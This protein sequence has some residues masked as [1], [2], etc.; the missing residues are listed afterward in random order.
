MP[1]SKENKQHKQDPTQELLLMRMSIQAVKEKVCQDLDAMVAQIERL[2]PPENETRYQR[3]KN[4]SKEDW[5]K[6]TA[7]W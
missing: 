5:K 1:R 3:H 7:N 2:L 6:I 4:L